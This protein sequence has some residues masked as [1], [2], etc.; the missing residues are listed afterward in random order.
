MACRPRFVV[1]VILVG[2]AVHVVIMVVGVL[3]G[4][5]VVVGVPICVVVVGFGFDI[6]L[7]LAFCR[8]CWCQPS[9]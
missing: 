7:W 2:V 5:D 1:G 3:V 9:P 6:A 8:S 4:F